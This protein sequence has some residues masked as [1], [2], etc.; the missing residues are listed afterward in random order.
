MAERVRPSDLL[1]VGVGGALGTAAR[2]TL[3]PSHDPAAFPVA[4]LVINVVGAGLLG[5]LVDRLS[6][7][8]PN[9]PNG[10]LGLLIGTGVLGGFTTY[11]T[12]ALDCVQ[13][14]STG[15]TG[16]AVAYGLGTL[17][18][19]GLAAGLGLRVDRAGGRRP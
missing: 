7:R 4:T 13:L 8:P 10:R 3:A 9:A 5:L 16:A 6:R 19:G 15:A 18:V 12:L 11:S 1:V 14:A 2:V 17:L